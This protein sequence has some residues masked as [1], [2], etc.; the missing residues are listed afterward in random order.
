MK[1]TPIFEEVFARLT[2]QPA[3]GMKLLIGGLLA[4]VPLLNILAFGYLYRFAR[5]VRRSGQLSLPEWRDWQGLFYDGLRFGAVWLAYWLLPLLIAALLGQVLTALHLDVLAY[6]LFT[7]TLLCA[8]VVFCAALY[9]FQTRQ[10]YGDLLDLP[11]IF[12]MSLRGTACFAVPSILVLGIV[13]LTLPLYGFAFFAGFVLMI[14]YSSLHFRA[15]EQRATN[16]H[17]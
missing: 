1:E 12:T 8:S 14:A 5:G 15:L 6:L 4:F 13:A 7:S 17:N 16:R 9:R 11:L 10:D 2:R 3:V